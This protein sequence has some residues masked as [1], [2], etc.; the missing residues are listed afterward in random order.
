MLP[1]LV[2]TDAERVLVTYLGRSRPLQSGKNRLGV[3]LDPHTRLL[4]RSNVLLDETLKPDGR[5]TRTSRMRDHNNVAL[6]DAKARISDNTTLF[7]PFGSKCTIDV[8]YFNGNNIVLTLSQV[9]A[10]NDDLRA[11]V[12]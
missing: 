3:L 10:T 11:R 2:N 8:A 1:G 6:V 7:F 5:C 12:P 9:L 4:R